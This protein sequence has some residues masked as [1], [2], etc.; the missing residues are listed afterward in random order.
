MCSLLS[1][2]ATSRALYLIRNVHSTIPRAS[3][4]TS[5]ATLQI[6]A[7]HLGA[8]NFS[9]GAVVGTGMPVA[10]AICSCQPVASD[11]DAAP[12]LAAE[13]PSCRCGGAVLKGADPVRA[14]LAA[15]TTGFRSSVAVGDGTWAVPE[16]WRIGEGCDM[17]M[18]EGFRSTS[19][20]DKGGEGPGGGVR[21]LCA[22]SQTNCGREEGRDAGVLKG[23]YSRSVLP[24][25]AP[26]FCFCNTPFYR[27]WR[28]RGICITATAAVP[29][30]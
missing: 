30:A 3:L 19:V 18:E 5:I 22:C 6:P 15:K 7:L 21:S 14:V 2:S 12:V 26:C 1:C 13:A 29:N 25:E 17:Q 24:T 27:A 20:Q 16:R 8:L 11:F 9:A 23:V 10:Q 4:A 28:Y